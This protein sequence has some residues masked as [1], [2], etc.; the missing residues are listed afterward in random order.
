M[1]IYTYI[2]IHIY[3]YIYAYLYNY[4]TH[5]YTFIYNYN[6]LSIT[7]ISLLIEVDRNIKINIETIPPS[8]FVPLKTHPAYC[9]CEILCPLMPL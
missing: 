4:N 6:I 2:Y 9:H 8:Q 5:T 1:S 3:I 7:H